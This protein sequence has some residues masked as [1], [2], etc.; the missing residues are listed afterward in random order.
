MIGQRIEAQP[1]RP[2]GA[3]L[4]SGVA[5]LLLVGAIASASPHFAVAAI[6]PL[7]IASAMLLTRP[8]R[9][10]AELTEEGLE[11][12]DSALLIPYAAIEGL[13]VTG[14]PTRP[15]APLYVFH[16]GGV[17]AVPAQLNLPTNELFGFLASRMSE[18]GSRDVPAPLVKY[19]SRQAETFGDAKVFSFR[20]RPHPT[21]YP[22]KRAVAVCLAVAA[23]GL[24]WLVVGIALGKNYA[25]WAVIGGFLA[26][27]FALF[28]GAFRLESGRRTRI[29]NWR[30]S[31]LVIGPAGLALIQGDMRGELRWGELRK[32]EYREKPR[33]FRLEGTAFRLEA[34]TPQR[35]IHLVVEGARIVIADIYDRPL[36]LI[37]DRI[38]SYWQGR[39]AN[40]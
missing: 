11:L 5:L 25:P 37:Y 26:F 1:G 4:L 18:S 13:T 9:F 36:P 2:W 34:D 31:G 6:L 12:T 19:L 38:R 16:A 15:R 8:G 33:S 23:T 21:P 35:G 28:A 30:Q 40:A 20:A 3:A 14:K 27:L 10:S 24:A 7:A 32:I 29:K 22:R 17:V 39:E